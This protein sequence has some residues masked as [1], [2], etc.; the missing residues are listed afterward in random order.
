MTVLRDRPAD[1]EARALAIAER[2][3]NVLID[4]GAGT[5]KTTLLVERLVELVAP[6]DDGPALTLERIA[7]ITFTRRAAGELR[8]RVR[9]RLIEGLSARDLSSVRRARLRG[10]L[11][12][13]DTAYIGTIHSFA[14]RLLRMR[15]SSARLDPSYEVVDDR[16]SL[17]ADTARLLLHGASRGTL[18][19]RLGTTMTAD[20]IEEAA[21]TIVDALDVGLRAVRRET[22][23]WIDHGLDSLVRGFVEHRD[24]DAPL[25]AGWQLDADALARA[26]DE[27]VA[28]G[29]SERGSSQAA[30]WLRRL[31]ENVGRID[32]RDLGALYSDVAAEIHQRRR[33]TYRFNLRDGC[34]GDRSTWER[35]KRLDREGPGGPALGDLVV[36]P[37]HRWMAS[38]LLSVRPVVLALYEDVKRE[39][40]VLDEID[41]LL[42]LRNLLRDDLD[43]RRFYQ[44]R[45]DHVFVDEFQDTDPLQAEILLYLTEADAVARTLE[46]VSPSPGRITIVGDPQQSIYRF[47]RA[48]VAAYSSICDR[49]AADA[50]RLQLTVNFRSAPALVQW[51]NGRF[52]GVFGVP[53]DDRRFDPQGGRVFHRDLLPGRAEGGGP[54]V[55]IVS[56]ES[57]DEL[58][59]E[60]W[61]AVEARALP[62]YL[63]WLVERSGTNLVDP[64][65]RA[66]RRIG[67]GDICVLAM[68]T[69]HLGLLFAELDALAIPYAASGSTLFLDDPMQ[70]RFILALRGVSDPT[71]GPAAAAL[72]LPPMFA[73]DPGQIAMARA[74]LDDGGVVVAMEDAIRELRRRRFARSP[75]ETARALLDTTCLGAA[76]AVGPNGAQR[77]QRLRELCHLADMLAFTESLDYDGVTAR[78]R[79]WIDHPAS[80]DAPPPVRPRAVRV[81]TIHQAKGLEFPV[82]ALWDARARAEIPAYPSAWQVGRDGR[83][84]T[85]RLDGLEASEPAG[86]DLGAAERRFF[87]EERRRL[88]YVAV[89]RARDLLVV[90][91][92]GTPDA[93]LLWQPLTDDATGDAVHVAEP[94]VAGVG[95][96]WARDDGSTST[97]DELVDDRSLETEQR[98][99]WRAALEQS[100]RACVRS[101]A[102]TTAA[103]ALPRSATQ[104]PIARDGSDRE[105]RHGPQFGTA[106]HRALGLVLD[107]RGACDVVR[108]CAD[109]AVRAGVPSE[110]HAEVEL[111]VR[112]ALSTLQPLVAGPEATLRLEY[113]IAGLGSDGALLIGGIDLL[114]IDHET[115]WVIDFKTDRAPANAVTFDYPGYAAQVRLYGE[116]LAQAGIGGSCRTRCALLFTSDGSLHE[117]DDHAR[118]L[119]GPSWS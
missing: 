58:S 32:A 80:I 35:W 59:A 118:A 115:L 54:P 78:M 4:A 61:R 55:H 104:R 50:L 8:L 46:D 39:Q 21:A 11:S 64:E 44:S 14:D 17:V 100:K 77:L 25:G 74:G 47:R 26:L 110:L 53:A 70:Q 114:V 109:G 45:F 12:F 87:D 63:R 36:E 20:A 67:W 119:G 116:L 40:G 91:R 99:A 31:A 1:T 37:L 24:V 84:W 83:Q 79:G 34:G 51:G 92:A 33:A 72:R 85:I 102:V 15:P 60:A 48:D 93:R 2:R 56:L 41:L 6:H 30:V 42:L 3:R 52:R 7:A 97:V 106:V 82:V 65:S 111:D 9:A 29:G 13:V 16:E 27:L 57:V 75:G 62:R 73:V 98:S 23:Y 71:D 76:V 94:Y 96:A 117:I 19:Q 107:G 18:V 108:A 105:G 68:S 113:P 81:M 5:G 89:T 28:L 49:L 112:R 101:V 38:R 43:S 90:P 66:E 103:H 22:E 88:S 69:M 95:A 10:A 86:V